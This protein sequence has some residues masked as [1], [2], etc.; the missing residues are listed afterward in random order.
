MLADAVRMD[1]Y[2]RAIR[3]VVKPGDVVVDV[4]TGTGALAFLAC[5]AG[6]RRVFAI[7]KTHMADMAAVLV[8]HRGLTERVT[9][10]HEHSTKVDLPE[11][12]DVILTETLGSFALEEQILASVLDARRRLAR[13]GAALI[14]SHITL[15]LVP[16]EWPSLY[17]KVIDGWGDSPLRTFA[18]NTLYVDAIDE[19]AHLAEPRTIIELDL[20]T[21]EEG[22]ASGRVAFEVEGD[23]VLH[24]FSG[25]FDATLAPGI[26]LSNETARE[27]HWDHTFLPLERPLEVAEGTKIDVKLEYHGGQEWRWHGSVGETVFDQTTFLNGPP[28]ERNR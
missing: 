20:A 28:C 22:I 26:E 10:F 3:A 23:G 25:W 15:S 27:T 24:G 4:G 19:D 18:A 13:P 17:E 8:R 1:A 21:I 2:A 14:P 9:V 7:D 12:A 11:L 6:A 16:V 5:E